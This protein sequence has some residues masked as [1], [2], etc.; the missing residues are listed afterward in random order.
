MSL[1]TIRRGRQ[2]LK[3]ETVSDICMLKYNEGWLTAENKE[4][5]E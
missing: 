2:N 3:P 5:N 1:I 4:Q